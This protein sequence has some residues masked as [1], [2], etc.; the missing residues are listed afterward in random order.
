MVDL[1]ASCS[2]HAPP[3]AAT[4]RSILV[5]AESGDARL[6]DLKNYLPRA[7]SVLDVADGPTLGSPVASL[8]SASAMP[9]LSCAPSR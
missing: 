4:Y 9:V 3:L 2:Q 1:P 7:S 5:L 8:A 6:T